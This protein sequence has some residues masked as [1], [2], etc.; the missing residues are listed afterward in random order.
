MYQDFKKYLAEDLDFRYDHSR[1]AVKAVLQNSEIDDKRP[2]RITTHE[3]SPL[4]ISVISGKI[5][6]IFDLE[7]ELGKF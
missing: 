2:T 6:N 7:K 5:N 1:F 3:D 4:Y